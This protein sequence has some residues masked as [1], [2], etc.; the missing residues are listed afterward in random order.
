[1]NI[2]LKSYLDKLASVA[3]ASRVETMSPESQQRIADSLPAGYTRSTGKILGRGAEGVANQSFTGGG[4]GPSV[5]K[6][7]FHN[8]SGSG[9]TQ[10]ITDKINLFNQYPE[11]F[12]KIHHQVPGGYAMERLTGWPTSTST[13]TSTPSYKNLYDAARPI[14]ENGLSLP[15]VEK[16]DRPLSGR[17]PTENR[18]MLKG[19]GGQNFEISDIRDSNIGTDSSGKTKVFDP[20]INRISQGEFSKTRAGGADATPIVRNPLFIPG[21]TRDWGRVPGFESSVV[22]I[23]ATTPKPPIVNKLVTLAPPVLSRASVTP[24]GFS[25]NFKP[26]GK[27]GLRTAKAL[28]LSAGLSLAIKK[29]KDWWNSTPAPAPPLAP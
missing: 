12:P 26:T 23:P 22:Q 20:Q 7:F 17:T 19:T 5:T 15:E 8:Q 24:T 29:T 27:G 2:Y 21:Q 4:V 13:Q 14:A 9:T 3:F 1:M 18:I 6:R 25:S 11:I 16:N 28:A 10:N